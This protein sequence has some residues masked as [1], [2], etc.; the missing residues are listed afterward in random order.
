MKTFYVTFGQRWRQEAHPQ[1]GHPD[2]WFDVV[3]LDIDH[4]RAK[5]CHLCDAH[6]CWLYPDEESLNKE[7][8]P[9]GCLRRIE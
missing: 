4:A 9:L 7:L 2:G 6:W 5:I 3:A 8:Y 1:G